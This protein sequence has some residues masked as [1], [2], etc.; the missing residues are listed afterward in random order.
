MIRHLKAYWKLPE[1]PK[2][3]LLPKKLNGESL[4]LVSSN[5][6]PKKRSEDE[7]TVRKKGVICKNLLFT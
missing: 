3:C 4:S 6:H 5:C 2:I 1:L 7:E